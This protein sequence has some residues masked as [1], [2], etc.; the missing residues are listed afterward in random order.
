MSVLWKSFSHFACFSV[1]VNAQC[2]CLVAIILYYCLEWLLR[3]TFYTGQ[4]DSKRGSALKAVKVFSPHFH[5]TGFELN[6]PRSWLTF[7]AES[8]LLNSGLALEELH[9]C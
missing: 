6:F 1:F 8:T 5:Q 2:S 4:K 3:F 7:R 9:I